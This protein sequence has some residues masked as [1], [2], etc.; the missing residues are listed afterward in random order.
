MGYIVGIVFLVGLVSLVF[1]GSDIKNFFSPRVEIREVVS[2]PEILIQDE[3]DNA[4]EAYENSS[5]GKE[6]LHT[7]AMQKALAD[8]RTKLDAIEKSLL[9]KEASL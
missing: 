6:V 2:D 7:W 9:E 1:F 4:V 8:Q 5:E 3:F